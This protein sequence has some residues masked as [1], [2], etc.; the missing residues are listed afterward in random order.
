MS[1]APQVQAHLSPFSWPDESNQAPAPVVL[2]VLGSVRASDSSCPVT[3]ASAAR[4]CEC[5]PE[6]SAG[7]QPA[8]PSRLKKIANCTVVVPHLPLACHAQNPALPRLTS[9]YTA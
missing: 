7:S 2:V 6:V 9:V 3:L 8:S 1:G 5:K 4:P